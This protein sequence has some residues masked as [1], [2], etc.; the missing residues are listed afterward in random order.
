MA[1]KLFSRK[2]LQRLIFP[3]VAE[4]FLAMTIGACDTV[5]VSSVG[6]AGVSGVSLIDQLTQLFIQLFAAFAT[7]GAV[8][9]SQ[10]LGHKADEN[11]RTAARQLL[12]I[13]TFAAIAIIAVCLPLKSF[14]LNLIYG[15]IDESVMQNAL[16]Y[17]V[18]VL[19]SFPFLAIYNSCAALFRSM[20]NSKISL[21]VSL[22]MNLTNIAGNALLIYGAKIGVAGAGIAT[23]VSRI[24]AAIVM[25]YLL[26]R[27]GAKINSRI[28]LEKLWKI[29]I[30]FDMIRKILRVAI[31][32]GIENSVFH[33]GKI[34]VY[35]FMSGFG[36]AAIA[37]NAIT[38][39]IASFSNIPA[40]AI[41]LSSVTV[42]G[43]C[44]GAGEKEQ[45]KSYGRKLMK[46]AYIGMFCVATAI[47]LLAPLLVRAF[48][49]SDEARLLATGVIRTCMVANI[50]FW[51]MSFT[52]P[53]ILRAS[54]DAK[55]TMVVSNI[56]MWLFR[57]LFS[58]LISKYL[59]FKFPENTALALYGIWFGMYIDWVFRGLCFGLRFHRNRWL[60]KRVI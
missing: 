46:E 14:I 3:L 57:V 53:N 58:F 6:E 45:A 43:Q 15:K 51:P 17:F 20:G 25:L 28:Y 41:G 18:W 22:M 34:L 35:S 56:S 32:S 40:Q 10:Y 31:P 21:K 55:F 59:L 30:R 29:E 60:D 19:L 4:Q 26:A 27:P 1:E 24:V 52:M 39:T 7:G 42:I 23:L 13:S 12:Y 33:I 16:V 2:D 38:N 54:G 37:A 11:A 8:V 36:L 48:N 50:F 5:M 47:F 9:S 44:I 49:L